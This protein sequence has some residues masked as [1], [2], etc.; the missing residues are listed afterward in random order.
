MYL[1]FPYCARRHSWDLVIDAPDGNRGSNHD[2]VA[3]SLL[4]CTGLDHMLGLTSQSA[5]GRTLAGASDQMEPKPSP[6]KASLALCGT[7]GADARRDGLFR[8][9]ALVPPLL[10]RLAEEGSTGASARLALMALAFATAWAWS[11]VFARKLTLAPQIHQLSFAMMF[12]L[13]LPA[14]VG[15]GGAFLA[16]SFGW[17][18][19]DA[20][21]GGKPILPPALVAL[22]FAIFSFPG[23]GYEAL[24]LLS[25]RPSL[26]LAISCLPGAAWLLWKGLLPWRI[27]AGAA[28]G[29]AAIALLMAT[30]SSPLWW[31]HF[32]LGTFSIGILFL[33]TSPESGPRLQGARWLYGGIV[34]GMIIVIR[35]ASPDHPDGVVLAVLVG[36]LL[37]PLLDRAVNWRTGHD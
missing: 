20:I 3:V 36:S 19:G 2:R 21:F 11:A 22:A 10:V 37:A 7:T 31:E 25:A 13:M 15:M 18:V 27:V 16:I 23:G 34:G 17:V 24:E 29:T 26:M 9:M 33:A 8:L 1:D 30:P 35:I 4:T 32:I 14:S 6:D 12:T 28:A 5:L